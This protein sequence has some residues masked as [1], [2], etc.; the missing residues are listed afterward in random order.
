MA[1]LNFLPHRIAE[2]QKRQQRFY[3]MFCSALMASAISVWIAKLLLDRQITQQTALVQLLQA[4]HARLDAQMDQG[5]N[6][7]TKIAALTA[8]LQGIAALHQQKN[9]ATRLLQTLAART[10]PK[11]HLRTFKQQGA[12]ITLSGNAPSPT[13]IV[14]LLANLREDKGALSHAELVE[15]HVV[16]QLPGDGKAQR[17]SHDFVIATE[18]AP[19]ARN[20]KAA[21]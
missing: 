21:Q 18:R 3:L 4:E 11:I 10:P 20:S 2:E 15:T 13:D 9:H 19:V 8:Q 12:H 5:K 16:Q 6:L 7:Q 17:T 1:K 14:Q